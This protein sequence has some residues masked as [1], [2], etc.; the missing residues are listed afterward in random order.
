MGSD[1][2]AFVRALVPEVRHLFPSD[3]RAVRGAIALRRL[4]NVA[5]GGGLV[6]LSGES[7]RF[8]SRRVHSEGVEIAP[9]E[10][11]DILG[12]WNLVV[13]GENL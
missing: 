6:S 5:R 7:V 12:L 4:V 1:D 8:H 2:K 11:R 9:D 13:S 3:F 10:M